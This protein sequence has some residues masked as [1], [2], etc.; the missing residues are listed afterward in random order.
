ME[1]TEKKQWMK[2]EIKTVNIA[3]ETKQ[4]LPP[5]QPEQS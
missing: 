4:L 1:N 5:E 2:P 3:S